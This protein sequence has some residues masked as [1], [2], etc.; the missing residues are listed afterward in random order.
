MALYKRGGVLLHNLVK[1]L[2]ADDVGVEDQLIAALDDLGNAD[3]CRRHPHKGYIH[4]PLHA[5]GR[6][7][8]RSISS[9]S[10]SSASAVVSMAAIRL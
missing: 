7:P 4:Q 10:T 1:L 2:R 8:Y 6:L 5:S 9:S 3:P